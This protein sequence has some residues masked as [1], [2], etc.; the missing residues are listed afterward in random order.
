MNSASLYVIFFATYPSILRIS[1]FI[2]YLAICLKTFSIAFAQPF[3]PPF[4]YPLN[5][6]FAKFIHHFYLML[7]ISIIYPYVYDAIF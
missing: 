6:A 3:Q 4:V 1:L 7:A 5:L 2:G